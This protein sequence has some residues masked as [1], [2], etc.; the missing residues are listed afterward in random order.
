MQEFYSE[1]MEKLSRPRLVQVGLIQIEA[2]FA[3]SL[4]LEG[5]SLLFLE[6]FTLQPFCAFQLPFAY[7]MDGYCFSGQN[8]LASNVL[9]CWGRRQ[10]YFIELDYEAKGS[11]SLFNTMALIYE[12]HREEVI[13]PEIQIKRGFFERERNIT[14]A[15]KKNQDKERSRSAPPVGQSFTAKGI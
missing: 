15:I 13:H 14:Q 3:L 8:L 9:W 2:K 5:G 10:S 12:K 4:M 7:F 1:K 6:P 11:R